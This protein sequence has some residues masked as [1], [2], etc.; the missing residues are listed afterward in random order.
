MKLG[1]YKIENYSVDIDGN[2]ENREKITYYNLQMNVITI[3]RFYDFNQILIGY[4]PVE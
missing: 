1:Y 3:E 2:L 4:D